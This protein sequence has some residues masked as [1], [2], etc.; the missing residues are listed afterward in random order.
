[1]SVTDTSGFPDLD[2]AAIK[3]AKATRYAAGTDSDKSPPAVR[4]DPA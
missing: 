4:Q 1:M 3:I 2:G